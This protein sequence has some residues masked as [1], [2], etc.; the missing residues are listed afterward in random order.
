M[1]SHLASGS[2][3]SGLILRFISTA[4]SA[5]ISETSSSPSGAPI[6]RRNRLDLTDLYAFSK[7][8]RDLHIIGC[9]YC[10]AACPYGARSFNRQDPRP[11]IAN[12]YPDFPMRTQG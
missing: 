4:M 9:R 7:P 10:M 3:R 11:A 5:G 12:V 2:K 8:V 6:F 1:S